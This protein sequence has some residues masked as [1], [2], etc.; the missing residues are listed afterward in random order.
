[1]TKSTRNR[2]ARR[3][4]LGLLFVLAWLVSWATLVSAQ[5]GFP[6]LNGVVADDTGKVDAAAVN[7]A[8]ADLQKLNP[9]VKPL[10]VIVTRSVSA[11]DITDFGSQAVANYGFS[12]NG[13]VD[14]NILAI[15]VSVGGRQT[16]I[17]YGDALAGVMTQERGG[18]TV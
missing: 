6:T 14:P 4:T 16:V 8:A 1:M 10:A 17:I 3:S 5:A 13:V 7:S 11:S 18:R 15:V 9:A 12:K 2:P